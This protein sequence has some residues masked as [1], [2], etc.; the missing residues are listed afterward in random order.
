[1]SSP[2]TSAPSHG[3]HV[4]RG[5]ALIAD[6][7]RGALVGQRGDLAWMCAPRW[8]SDAVFATLLGD[9]SAYTVE[10]E[11]HH[12]VWGGY[13]EP[14]TLI[15]RSRWVTGSGVVECR[16]ALAAP[17]DDAVAVVLRRIVAVA[18]DAAV[19]LSLTPAAGFGRDR[20][21]DLHCTDG[22][23]TMR[24]GD[25]RLRWS[26]APD[27]R[28]HGDGLAATVHLPAG[29]H[30]DLVLEIAVGEL[31]A[32]PPDAPAAWQATERFWRAEVPEIRGTL[33]DR[34]AGHAY[35]VLRGLTSRHGG[36]VAAATTSLPERARRRRNYDYRYSWIRDQCLAGQAIAA[37]GAYPLLDTAVDFVDARLRAD[38][39]DLKP[40]YRVG[41]G[42]VPDERQVD[43][44]GYPGGAV[45][46]GN[47]VNEQFQLDA[48]GEALL[49]F[50]AAD[51]HDRLD[52]GHWRAV[53]IAAAAIEQRW[54]DPD[55]GI[56]EL[57]DAWWTHSRLIC[58][59]GLRAV[60][61]A[62]PPRQAARWSTL[63]D[64]LLAATTARCLDPATGRWRRTP[65]DRRPDA[66]LLLPALRGA[67]PPDDPRSLRTLAAIRADLARDGY[68]YRYRHGD[69]PLA[70]EEG[71]FLL[72]GQLMALAEHRIGN[73]VEAVR[74][75]ERGRAA[76]GPPG[77]FTDEFDVRQRQLRGNI[78]QAFVHALLFETAHRLDRPWG[79]P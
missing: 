67:L 16:D 10:P 60:A 8:D 48:F 55:A 51:R 34:D 73:E 33:A 31:P 36:M 20:A 70:E 5:Y 74:W 47:W 7:E 49:L 78:P 9:T 6:G 30:L 17:A 71:A 46:C 50:A 22:R 28:P 72:C 3:P 39:A 45:T 69:R 14:D 11:G 63:A 35:A 23:W 38:G 52:R 64:Q 54:D 65:T 12:Y 29:R 13:Y 32:R 79:E 59:A 21:R 56:W 53:E 43:L 42:R 2:Q 1:M 26:G 66:A 77:L 61:R 25:T 44:P 37:G 19:T 18:G 76:C 24:C 62:A 58:V 68:L 4:L 75:F 27:A 40:A 41:G 15:W 57:D